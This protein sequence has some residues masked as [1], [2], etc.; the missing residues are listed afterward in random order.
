MQLFSKKLAEQFVH[1]FQPLT[2]KYNL[3]LYLIVLMIV[4]Y[5]VELLLYLPNFTLKLNNLTK[6]IIIVTEKQKWCIVVKVQ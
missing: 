6:G 2:F 4:F 3:N 1:N 5:I